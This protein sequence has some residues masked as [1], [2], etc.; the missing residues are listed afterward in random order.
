MYK[1]IFMVKVSK[2][3]GT[4]GGDSAICLGDRGG[5][6]LWGILAGL[7]ASQGGKESVCNAGDAGEVGSVS[8]SG[9]SPGGGEGNPLQCSGLGKSHG[10][11]SPVGYSPRGRKGVGHD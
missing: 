4:Q 8:G 6:R 10:Q 5:G 1:H 2:L 7:R 9:R 3:Q 11:R